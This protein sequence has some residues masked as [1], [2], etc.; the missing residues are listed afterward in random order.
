MAHYKRGSGGN[1]L[2]YRR[3]HIIRNKALRT[4]TAKSADSVGRR[5]T[6]TQ[7]VRRNAEIVDGV[8]LN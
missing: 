4:G 6:I 8:S 7:G 5:R 2:T 3:S 1:R